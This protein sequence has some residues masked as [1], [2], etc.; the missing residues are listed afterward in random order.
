M[1]CLTALDGVGC[2]SGVRGERS[3]IHSFRC[4]DAVTAFVVAMWNP[5]DQKVVFEAARAQL[6]GCGSPPINWAEVPTFLCWVAAK[7][8]YFP[9]LFCMDDSSRR[10]GPQLHS[11]L[12][13]EGSFLSAFVGGVLTR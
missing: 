8:L 11:R 7:S 4:V 5:R 3:F 6:F 10:S 12:G 2:G 13:L 9:L 1:R